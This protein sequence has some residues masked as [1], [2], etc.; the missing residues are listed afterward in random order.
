MAKTAKTNKKTSKDLILS[1]SLTLRA[2]SDIR[3]QILS[4]LDEN[5]TVKLLLQEVEEVDLSFV[6]I[7]CAAH[8]SAIQK[9]KSLLVQ[10]DLPEV[11]TKII[12]EAGLQGHIGCSADGQESCVWIDHK[13]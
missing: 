13:I 7:F 2:A 1:G 5:E 8:R 3:Q 10:S 4:A 11:F 6:Q 12:K 9:E